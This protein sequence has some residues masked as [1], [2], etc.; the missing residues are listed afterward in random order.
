MKQYKILSRLFHLRQL[1]NI[2]CDFWI[3]FLKKHMN[4]FVSVVVEPLVIFLKMP[5]LVKTIFSVAKIVV[6]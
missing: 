4:L 5:M 1:W 3:F 2:I 6:I